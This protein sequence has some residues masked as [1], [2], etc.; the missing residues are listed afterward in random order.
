[1]SF[2]T[3]KSPEEC[4]NYFYR[5][6]DKIPLPDNRTKVEQYL[7]E[8]EEHAKY[9]TLGSYL[10]HIKAFGIWL[11]MTPWLEA[12]RDDVFSHIKGSK[13][14]PGRPDRVQKPRKP[15]GKY[16]KYQ[17]MVM[18]RDFYKWLL[19]TEDTPEQFRRLPFRKPTFEE[20]SR[21]LAAK[22]SKEEVLRMLS[23]ACNSMDRALIMFLLDSGFR[24][25][26]VSA[27]DIQDVE[28]D[29]Y[30]ALVQ[31]HE[32]VDGLKTGVR[33]VKIRITYATRYV[34][35]WIERHPGGLDGDAPLFISKSHRNGGER[36][37]ASAIWDHVSRI[38][39]RAG[40]R[41]IHP[42]M[43]RHSCVSEAARSG[44]GE[45]MM[46]LRFGWRKG[47]PMPSHYSHVADEFENYSRKM[48]GIPINGAQEMAWSR[49][50]AACEAELPIEAIQCRACGRDVRAE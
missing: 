7:S 14:I 17:R 18:L 24:S 12:T 44:W 1:M 23:A 31:H 34:R 39:M 26:E 4:W 40:L 30:G 38:S 22:L 32:V 29:E 48:A 3:G 41:H 11:Q 19:D 46:R 28:F 16:S 10:G 49:S 6:I 2:Y 35:E 13:G 20:Q 21:G 47:S 42:H 5:H 37:S 8:K 33:K 43:F 15:L 9:S 25:G 27:L 45:E 36:L 50:C